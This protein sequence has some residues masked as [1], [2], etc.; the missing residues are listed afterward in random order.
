M[1]HRCQWGDLRGWSHDGAH[2]VAE[3]IV[4]ACCWRD[5]YTLFNN[6]DYNKD[7]IIRLANI[8]CNNKVSR[9]YNS[10]I[11]KFAISL[12]F[13]SLVRINLYVNS[14]VQFYHIQKKLSK[15]YS[16]VDAEPCIC[17]ES[18]NTLKLK[19]QNSNKKNILCTYNCWDIDEIA[20]RKH[21]EWDGHTCYGYV[22]FGNQLNPESLEMATGCFVFWWSA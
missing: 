8:N 6:F 1:I 7:L 12:L 21:V 15:W 13:F 16:S 10:T 14:S 17:A 11:R 19:C 22:D 9:M 2:G 18:F 20:I 4:D 3:T 5:R